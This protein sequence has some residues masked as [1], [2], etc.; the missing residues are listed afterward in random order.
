MPTITA[1][2]QQTITVP[3]NSTLYLG[4]GLGSM[5]VG[6]PSNSARPTQEENYDFEGTT[7]GPFPTSVNVL[8]RAQQAT[9]YN[10]LPILNPLTQSPVYADQSGT[11]Y[12]G[13]SPVSGAGKTTT[14]LL[15]DSIMQ[16]YY[17]VGSGTTLAFL[18]EHSIITWAERFS[19]G[20]LQIGQ[21]LA[22]AGTRLAAHV[23]QAASVDSSVTAI[24]IE[25]GG[26]NDI[27]GDDATVSYCLAQKKA[28]WT[29]LLAKGCRVVS[30]SVLPVAA[31]GGGSL[32]KNQKIA[33]FNAACDQLAP[34]YGVRRVNLY[35]VLVDPADTNGYPLAN[36]LWD[37]LHPSVKGGY[38]CGYRLWNSISSMYGAYQLASS[39]MDGYVASTNNNVWIENSL[40]TGTS[41]TKNAQG[42]TGATGTVADGWDVSIPTGGSAA[43]ACSLVT[44]PDGYGQALNL[45]I[46]AAAANDR[47]EVRRIAIANGPVTLDSLMSG[48]IVCRVV[49]GSNVAA[50]VP[51]CLIQVDATNNFVYGGSGANSPSAYLTGNTPADNRPYLLRTP[52]INANNLARTGSTLNAIR[53]FVG[54]YMSGAGSA[55][56]QLSRARGRKIVTS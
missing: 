32:A 42:G 19:L 46:T 28:L 33:A 37:G 7:V 12:A 23:T 3:A 40:F 5:I 51:W 41:G 34:S 54:I 36:V 43:V 45:A 10:V 8:V 1:G 20:A 29:A 18:G 52:A 31:A 55:V 4:G 6:Y 11:L 35:E 50:V 17:A 47:I 30:L 49:S 26:V 2:T 14:A 27:V 21:V 53:F 22:V 38:L 56:V 13:A 39:P 25:N 24:V 15:G 44:D 16:A 9:S 48:E